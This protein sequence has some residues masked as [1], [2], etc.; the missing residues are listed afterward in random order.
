MKLN[1][2]KCWGNYT[3]FPESNVTVESSP[4]SKFFNIK[5]NCNPE[6]HKLRRGG[7]KGSHTQS[8]KCLCSHR[9]LGYKGKNGGRP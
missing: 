6:N 5:N 8:L 9:R 7:K 2:E 3:Y 1:V 4:N